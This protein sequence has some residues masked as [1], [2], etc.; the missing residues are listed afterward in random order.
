MRVSRFQGNREK[1]QVLKYWPEYK[2]SNIIEMLKNM[3]EKPAVCNDDFT[4]KTVIIT[5]ATSGIG[6]YTAMKYASKG[7]K[8][9]TINRNREK[10]EKL[11]SDIEKNYGVKS[12]YYLADLSKLQDIHNVADFLANLENPIDVLIHNAGVYLT[13]KTLT[14]DGLETNFV[15]H[16]LAPF[17]INYKL[18]EK[19]RNDKRGR[20]IL[21]NSEAYRFAAW[22]LRF[23]DLQFEKRKYTGLKA[24]G[25]AKLAQILSMHIFAKILS[26]HGVT[27]NAMHP[28]VVKTNTG[29]DNGH[30]YRWYKEK[31]IDRFSQT[32]EVSAEALYYLGVSKDVEGVTDKFFHF[33]K[34]EELAPPAKDTLAAEKLWNL[35]LKITGLI[36]V[37]KDFYKGGLS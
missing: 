10:S 6:Y 16:Y 4:G 33:T 9:I 21:V 13:K 35:T 27:I 25:S 17:I 32:P 7:A 37:S 24:Y 19:Y 11:V 5:G 29:K 23:D 36:D 34:T 3:K 26:L 20:I 1:S 2:W 31:F 18:I 28:G 15:V 14:T 12:E 30:L 8:I 22:G